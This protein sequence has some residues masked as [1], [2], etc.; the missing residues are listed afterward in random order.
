MDRITN[1]QDAQLKIKKSI[2]YYEDRINAWQQVKRVYKKDGG[3][4]QNIDR[5]FT[6]AHLLSEY[7]SN[8]VRVNFRSTY[9]GYTYDDLYLKN[10]TFDGTPE[11]YNAI[12]T[13]IQNLIENYKK[14]RDI[15]K[16]G[17]EKIESQ[18]DQINPLLND[19]K[20]IIKQ[21]EVETNTHYVLKAYIKHC[22]GIF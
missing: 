8:K 17:L 2:A 14:W 7:G 18:L 9:E 21:A 3:I 5:N 11:T 22:L 19:L 13:H 16:A 15:D 12:E 10:I 1:L 4:F 20:Q 6:N